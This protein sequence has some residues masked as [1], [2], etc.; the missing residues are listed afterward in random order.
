V[1]F[2]ADRY[3]TPRG[4]ASRILEQSTLPF[5][6]EV[7]ADSTCGTGHLLEAAFRVYGATKCIGIDN[8]RK[9]I[10]ELRRKQPKW[11][12]SVGNVLNPRSYY[13]S[14]VSR[15]V[16]SCDLL[17]LNPPFSQ[18]RKKAVDISFKDHRLRGSVAMAY[19]LRSFELFEPAAGAIAIVPESLLYSE[20]DS[21][22]R[23]LI[24][25][26]YTIKIIADLDAKTFRGARAHATAVQFAVTENGRIAKHISGSGRVV[27]VTGVRGALP[28]HLAKA[29]RKGRPY[30][31]T[32]N[33]RHL[34]KKVRGVRVPR[35]LVSAKGRMC[36]WAILLPRVGVPSADTI[37][38]VFMPRA[39]QLSDCVIGLTC[40]T[41]IDAQLVA[42]RICDRMKL[43]LGA[44][45][46]TGARYITL[47]RLEFVLMRFNIRLTLD[48]K[49]QQ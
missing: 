3:Y 7:C 46:G 8:D 30:V 4:V 26:R 15:T 38:P 12:L 43:F 1:H 44:Y 5:L 23:K 37:G 18:H 29:G 49:V 34:L 45:R 35:T 42:S 32:T 48:L 19:L 14:L 40:A 47:T 9:V 27:E 20:T 2:D 31:H 24:E 17:V 25:E 41:E 21:M 28:V 36:G 22:A 13:S 10:S 16:D 39:V 6:P 33:I 11:I